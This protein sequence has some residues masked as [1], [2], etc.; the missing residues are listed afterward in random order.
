MSHLF[1]Y[2][3]SVTYE[4]S[5]NV[6]DLGNT[7]LQAVDE[8]NYCY[9]F[10]TKTSLG[11]TSCLEYGPI[12]LEDDLLPDET[13][14]QFSRFEFSNKT[15]IKKINAFLM[16]KKNLLVKTKKCKIIQVTELS[17]KEALSFGVNIFDYLQND[18]N[19]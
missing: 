6:E 15:I 18:E 3:G 4:D 17:L 7:C 9:F 1:N 14:I 8:L 10:I 12:D 5:V 16:P 2:N 11:I 13:N 19:Y